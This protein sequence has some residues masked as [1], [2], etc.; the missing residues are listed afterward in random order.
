M[1]CGLTSQQPPV[2]EDL[3]AGA[4]SQEIS[5]HL[6]ALVC[7]LGAAWTLGVFWVPLVLAAWVAQLARPIYQYLSRAMRGRG[8]SASLVTVLLVVAVF[9]PLVIVLL[10]LTGDAIALIQK[11]QKSPSVTGALAALMDDTSGGGDAA[12][13]PALT[14]LQLAQ[15]PEQ[16]LALIKAHGAGALGIVGQVLGVTVSVLLGFVVFVTG[17]YSNLVN[18]RAIREWILV[19]VP[20]SRPTAE[21]M[22]GAFQE[23]GQGLLVGVGLTALAQGTVAGI[24]FLVVGV[25]HGLVLGLL[26]AIAALVPSIGTGL[27]WVPV[28]AGLALSG[29]NG[30]AIAIVVL[31]VVVGSVDNVV[32]PMLS[33]I[34]KLQLPAFLLF[35]ALLGGMTA[36]GPVGVLLGPLLVR[37]AVEALTLS[38]ELRDADTAPLP[39]P[40]SSNERRDTLV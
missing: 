26:T 1:L 38:R 6:L 40:P 24:G 36:F 10:S 19:N 9:T 33:R 13:G 12:P 18:G 25:P 16:L 5:M 8:R 7:A 34:G 17:F 21:R 28:A 4:R 27:V 37:L 2:Q 15:N 11:I 39:A 30:A 29:R 31:G 22:I 23:T 14:G 20:L 35:L 32:R 3:P